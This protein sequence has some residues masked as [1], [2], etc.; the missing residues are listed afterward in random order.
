MGFKVSASAA[1]S[2]QR[3]EA[4]YNGDGTMDFA[5]TD[6]NAALQHTYAV[7]G[8]YQ[9][10]FNVTDSQG[11]TH[12]LTQVIVLVSV[13]SMDATL[14]GTYSGMLARLR[15]GDIDN[16]LAAFTASANQKYRA[17]FTALKPNLA[18]VVDQLGAIQDGAISNE[19]AEYS[20]VRNLPNGQQAFLIYFIR[21][22]DGVWRLDAM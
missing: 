17:V 16:A 21:G 1:T 18:S 2:I 13:A 14:R 11:N 22:A 5:S 4:D 12:A 10:R 20:I 6:P 8:I 7:P 19:F 3:I 9:A 15:A